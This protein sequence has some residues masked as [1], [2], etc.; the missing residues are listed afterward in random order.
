[1]GCGV[2]RVLAEQFEH[3]LHVL[4]IFG[5]RVGKTFLEIIVTIRQRKAALV[6]LDSVEGT[7]FAVRPEASAEY[8]ANAAVVE[9][10]QQG[11]D[12][13]ARFDPVNAFQVGGDGSE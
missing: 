4:T 13:A 3:F 8:S 7:V 6:Q 9:V 1:M 2:R 10:G 5:A 11:Q 12:V